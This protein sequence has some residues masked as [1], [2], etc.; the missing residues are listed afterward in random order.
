MDKICSPVVIVEVHRAGLCLKFGILYV[1][2]AAC[3]T[4]IGNWPSTSPAEIKVAALLG[5]DGLM[6]LAPLFASFR[7]LLGLC[8][9]SEACAL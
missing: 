5:S 9:L 2:L 7:G 6:L 3:F 4:G 1:L 8:L